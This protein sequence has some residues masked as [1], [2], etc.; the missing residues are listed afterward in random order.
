MS[1]LS[2]VGVY[3]ALVLLTR[4]MGLRSFSKMSSFDFAITVAFGSLLAT[5]V[6]SPRPPLLLTVGALASL[7]AIQWVVSRLRVHSSL[8]QGVIDNDPRLLMW[9][10]EILTDQLKRTGVTRDDL[11]AKLREANVL[12]FAQVRAVVLESTGDVSV[13]HGD[14]DG[15]ALEEGILEGVR[16]PPGLEVALS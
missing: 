16:R 1:F 8:L 12:S 5:A 6:V 13:L 15:P 10:G 2:A 3:L 9:E 4:A 11:I 14:Q 7:F